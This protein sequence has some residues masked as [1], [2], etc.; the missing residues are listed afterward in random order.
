MYPTHTW[1]PRV[2]HCGKHS[3]VVVPACCSSAAQCGS[4]G[5]ACASH[6][7]TVD[8]A[9]SGDMK[10]LVPQ[11]GDRDNCESGVV[12]PREGTNNIDGGADRGAQLGNRLIGNVVTDSLVIYRNVADGDTTPQEIRPDTSV[13]PGAFPAGMRNTGGRCR[14]CWKCCYCVSP[15]RVHSDHA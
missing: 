9:R 2:V 1:S 3:T 4:S 11:P 12:L 7:A 10:S 15:T 14:G 8:A 5:E 6:G 13:V